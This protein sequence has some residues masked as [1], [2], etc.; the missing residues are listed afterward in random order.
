MHCYMPISAT[1]FHIG[2]FTPSRQGSPHSKRVEATFITVGTADNPESAARF[3]NYLNGGTG[4][5]PVQDA[6]A[7]AKDDEPLD[8]PAA[9]FNDPQVGDIE[10]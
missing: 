2:Y 7:K 4:A 3:V 8:G 5:A 9:G 10:R 1:V 6:P